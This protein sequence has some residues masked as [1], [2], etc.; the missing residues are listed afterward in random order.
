MDHPRDKIG[1]VED[2]LARFGKARARRGNWET[3]WQQ[4]YDYTMPAKEQFRT[5]HQK[6][7][8]RR[9]RIYDSTAVN[10]VPKFA[11][12]IMAALTPS[13]SNWAKLSLGPEIDDDAELGVDPQEWPQYAELTPQEAVE[14]ISEKFFHFLHHS[15][16]AQQAFEAYQDLAVST[17][18][19]TMD[20]RDGGFIF[21]AIP[22]S[23]CFLEEGPSGSVQ[24]QWREL[25]VAVR[26]LQQTW[27]GLQMS[28]DLEAKLR[29]SPA[30]TVTCVEGVIYAPGRNPADLG[31]YHLVVIDKER[32]HLLLHV[33]HGESSPC[34]TAPWS[35][36]A[37]EVYGRGPV[38]LTLGDILTANKMME[39]K[40]RGDAFAV[41]G[42]W[43]GVSDGV[44]NPFTARFVPGSVISVASNDNANPS[45]RPL[46]LGGA[47]QI[48]DVDLQDLRRNIERALF[49]NPLGEVT[50]TPV[51]TL[52][53]NM[54]RMQDML[55]QAGASF[56]LLEREFAAAIVKRGIFLMS[57]EGVIPPLRVDGQAVTIEF[58]S[59]L[60]QARDTQE[61]QGV[62]LF[63]QTMGLLSPE[64]AP[65]LLKP[66]EAAE[67]VRERVGVPK[68]MVRTE[69][70]VQQIIA[71][72]MQA[73]AAA[74]GQQGPGG[75]GA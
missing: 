58:T 62:Q 73:M 54:M 46:P 61:L 74:Q 28:V 37:G 64:E 14:L 65:F 47:P 33:D 8:Y 40:L 31:S 43:T 18:S 57:R 17:L 21:Q 25:D 19:M 49:A 29:E 6:G 10:A 23:Q 3:M 66:S 9:E 55:E 11:T 45:L 15:N 67:Y 44:F 2:M 22:L 50:E 20:W 41:L 53:E 63:A 71:Q 12:R 4:A 56:G 30:D 36:A 39:H 26:N 51:R 27:P 16:F 7:E 48:V 68:R 75:M 72:R 35:R 52:G 60:A 1:T 69:D 38:I 32:G 42:L 70:E 59:P 24:T 13:W 5:S 34:L